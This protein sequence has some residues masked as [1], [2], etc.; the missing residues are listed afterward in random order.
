M[1]KSKATALNNKNDKVKVLKMW[2]TDNRWE[3][4]G[5]KKGCGNKETRKKESTP[6]H[7]QYVYT[8]KMLKNNQH[9]VILH[10]LKQFLV[11]ILT[12]INQRDLLF[13]I[14]I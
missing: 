2:L 1:Y 13:G 4:F 10:F 8:N 14:K 11:C 6:D 5:R 3:N 12:A 7:F 9:A